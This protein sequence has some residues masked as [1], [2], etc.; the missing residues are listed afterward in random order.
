MATGI[1]LPQNTREN[2]WLHIEPPSQFCPTVREPASLPFSS[3]PLSPPRPGS[4]QD[5][6]P[7]KPRLPSFS[8]FL[9]G[10]GRPD[11]TFPQSNPSLD[12]GTS[13]NHPLSNRHAA[14]PPMYGARDP[15]PMHLSE[16]ASQRRGYHADP[17]QG[18]F[19]PQASSVLPERPPTLPSV[20]QLAPL[21][22]PNH[23]NVPVAE[24]VVP[25]KG[26]CY[27]YS[28]GTVCQ[29]YING[30]AVNP[31]WGTTKAGKP[32]KRLGQA[33]NTCREKKIK[34]DP[35]VPKCAQCR[36]FGRECKFDS[37]YAP[38]PMCF[39]K[40]LTDLSAGLVLARDRPRRH[41]RCIRRDT[42]LRSNKPWETTWDAETRPHRQT[43]HL[44]SHLFTGQIPGFPCSWKACFL[45]PQ[46]PR[47]PSMTS[48]RDS[49]PQRRPGP[50]HLRDKCLKAA[51]R[52]T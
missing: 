51:I 32:R 52:R 41:L 2:Q 46:R 38:S 24:K 13:T 26:I 23:G 17:N 33:C 4:S 3:M 1:V 35:S 15:N 10:A 49:L 42:R 29:K 47:G 20:F 21:P 12:R 40:R 7:Q 37:T 39:E 28:D 27:V 45:P 50:H 34:C 19:W 22:D 25:G 6:F 5:A 43:G 8:N 9:S 14:Q 44:K 16:S 30:D 18:G 36:K 31:Q 11:L 48:P